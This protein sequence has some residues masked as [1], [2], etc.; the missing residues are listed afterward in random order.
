MCYPVLYEHAWQEFHMGSRQKNWAFS[1]RGNSTEYANLDTE[2]L[3]KLK[4]RQ[5]SLTQ[6][7]TAGDAASISR[8]EGQQKEIVLPEPRSQGHW[9]GAENS[10]DTCLAGAEVVEEA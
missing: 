3:Q 10:E 4:T 6:R 8:M 9:P 5:G 2:I 1:S 7:W